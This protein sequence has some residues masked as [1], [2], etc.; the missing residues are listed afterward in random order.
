MACGVSWEK[1]KQQFGGGFFLA[2]M[3][4]LFENAF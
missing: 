4:S 2:H 3:L 1:K